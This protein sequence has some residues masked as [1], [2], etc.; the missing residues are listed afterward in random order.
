MYLQY[1]TNVITAT[2]PGRKL[3]P[4]VR[5]MMFGSVVEPQLNGVDPFVYNL[6]RAYDTAQDD[7]IA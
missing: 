5:I 3:A 6:N 7:L 1:T 2:A 4:A